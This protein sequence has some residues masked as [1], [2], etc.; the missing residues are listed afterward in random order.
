MGAR[1]YYGA[2][3]GMADRLG[4]ARHAE[5]CLEC[6]LKKR[7][8]FYLDLR[9]TDQLRQMYLDCEKYDGYF[10]DRCVFGRTMDIEDTMNLV[11]RYDTGALM[12]YS[13]NAFMPWEGYRVAF[14]GTR[15][16]LEHD[17]VETV[18]I[19]GDGREQ[20]ATIPQ[21]TRIRLYPHFK[22]AREIPVAAAKGG[23][24]GGDYPLMA[25]LFA[26]RRPRDPYRRAAEAGA[27]AMSILTGVAANRSM[28]TGRPVRISSLIRRVPPIAWT[29]MKEW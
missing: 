10:R 3:T 9:K 6:R 15:G 2:E 22:P 11:V 16:R 23:H 19:S 18:Y 27:G 5:R 17:C 13:L 4:L 24:G 12:S 25:D 28:S 26:A 7:C 14:N 1:R 20:G 29:P 21:G 8:P